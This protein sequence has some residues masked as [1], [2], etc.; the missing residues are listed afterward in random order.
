MVFVLVSRLNYIDLP[1]LS[2]LFFKC[3]LYSQNNN[4]FFSTLSSLGCPCLT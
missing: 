1:N 2:P 3:Q 4:F